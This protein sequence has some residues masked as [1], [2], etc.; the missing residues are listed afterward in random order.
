MNSRERIGLALAH[1]EADRVG[2]HDSPWGATISRWRKEGLP[3]EIP[4]AEYFEYELVS[5]RAD[6]SPQFPVKVLEKDETYI[7]ETTPTGGVRRNFRD[8]STTPEVVDWP[9]KSKRDW[10]EIKERLTPDYTRVD[11][12]SLRT[13]YQRAYEEGKFVTFTGSMGYDCFQSYLKTEEMLVAMITE[14]D[15]VREM[16]QTQ[17]E[18]LIEMVKMVMEKG[19]KFDGAFLFN[20]MG[21]RNA[22]LFSPQSYGETHLE[23]DRMVCDFFHRHDMPVILHSCGC[24]KAL[25]PSLIEA[26]FDCLQ[27]L[28]VKAGM[29][30]M[31]L[32]ERYGDRMSFMGGID[33]RAM[34]HPDPKVIEEEIR[35][36][37]PAAKKGGGYIYHSDHSIPKNVSFQQYQRV[38]ALV[39]EYGQY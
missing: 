2:I 38:M 27:P 28:E 35:T 36:K 8:R 25:I 23:I 7:V 30:L 11:W 17:A 24:V 16:F 6:L 34:A 26:G 22:T 19:F 10:E 9:I 12:V 18:L 31:E 1:K 13:D 21:Y 37:L 4:V 29:D 39:E 33:V 5:F 15:W 32:K 3:D 14:P 20:D